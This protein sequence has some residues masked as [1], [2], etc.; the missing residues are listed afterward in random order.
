MNYK[1]KDKTILTTG[2]TGYVGAW[3]VKELLGKGYTVRLTV[4]DKNNKA[5]YAHVSRIAEQAAGTLEIWE[6]DLL[7]EG[8][9]DEAA[10]GADAILHIASPFTLSFKDAQKELIDPALGGTRNVLRAASNSGSVRKVVLTSSVAAI[11]GDTVDMQEQ[12]LTELTEEHFNT[13]SSLEHQPYSYSKVLAEKEAWKIQES[14]SDWELVV[15]NPSFVLGPSL[16]PSSASESLT[17]IKTLLS[18]KAYPAAPFLH[19]GFVDVR[20][21]A[22]AHRLALESEEASGRHIL[23]ACTAGLLDIAQI[24]RKK[25]PG[26]YLSPFLIAPKPVFYLIGWIFGMSFKFTQ[27]NIGYTL[28]LNNSK[29]KEA[30]GLQYRPLEDTVVDMVQQ[31]EKEK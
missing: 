31:M 10:K 17:I 19:F 4:R 3:V 30:L 2:G 27:R 24:V 26:K 29:S 15:L 14:Q 1:N 12:G 21:V 16:S 9:F 11:Y 25:F 8:S 13:S 7:R 20:E 6:A 22:L 18:G 23:S 5:G 28:V